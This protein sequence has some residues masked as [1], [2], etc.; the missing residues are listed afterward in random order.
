M[1]VKYDPAFY[2]FYKKANVR[3]RN[4]FDRQLKIFKINP[5]DPSLNN[6][7]L[8]REWE[9]YRSIDINADYRAIFKE[10]HLIDEILYYFVI[11]GTHQ[12]LYQHRKS[13]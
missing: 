13:N 9:G 1:K 12:D 11:L 2:V 10:I 7:V 8:E 4:A 3:L 5:H 6:H